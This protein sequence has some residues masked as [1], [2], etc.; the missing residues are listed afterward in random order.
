MSTPA[1]Q[2]LRATYPEAHLT[3]C[4]NAVARAA[5]Q[6]HDDVDAWLDQG[7][8][9]A[10]LRQMRSG[11]FTHCLLFKN[12]FYSALI[13]LLAGIPQRIGYARDGRTWLLTQLL[14]LNAFPV[15]SRVPN[16]SVAAT[17]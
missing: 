10:T 5:L 2:A 12:S 6:P 11:R 17:P 13:A 9:I 15:A 8:L 3:C 4:A 1:L 16:S 14:I 7:S